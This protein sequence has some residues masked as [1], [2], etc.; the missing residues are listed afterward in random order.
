MGAGCGSRT[1]AP[2]TAH[3]KIQKHFVKYGK[4]YKL[5][6]FGQHPI[7][8]VEIFEVRELQKDMAEADAYA[9]LAGGI[10]YKVRAT[11]LKKPFGWKLVSWENLGKS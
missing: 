10:T 7:E 4:K 11:F 5:S 2:T 6:D 8:R 9:T 3:N 1:P